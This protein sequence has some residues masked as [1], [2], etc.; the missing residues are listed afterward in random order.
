MLSAL[1]RACGQLFAPALRR[2]V[3]LSLAIAIA[4]FAVLWLGVAFALRHLPTVGWRLLDWLI[5]LLGIVGVALLSWLLFPAVVTIVMG[6]FLE[7]V[8]AG[9]EALDYPGRGPPRHQPIRETL[10]MGLR[11]T[12]LT[13][14]LNLAMLPVY[15]LLP[16]VNVFVFLALNGY[17][18]GRGYF[19]MVASRRLDMAAVATVRRR[20]DGRLFVAGTIITGMFALPFVNLIAPVVAIAFMVHVFEGLPVQRTAAAPS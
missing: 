7:R 1:I 17:L 20:F 9:V 15:V 19:E 16:G 4:S 12:L 3:V 2:V 6:L 8:A 10:A 13:I 5:D 18:L 11:L 14:A